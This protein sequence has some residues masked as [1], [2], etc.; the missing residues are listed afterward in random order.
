MYDIVV[1]GA[2]PSGSFLSYSLAKSGM[3]VLT[4]E[5]HSE[6]GRPVECTGVVTKRVF[7]FVHSK[8][9]ANVVHGARVFFPGEDPIHISKGEETVI[10]QRDS[11]DKD[12]ASMA[13][14]AG[15]EMQLGARLTAVTRGSEG[16]AVSFK[17][18]GNVLQEKAK[19]IVGADGANSTVRRLL[20]G[21]M[22]KRVVSTYQAEIPTRMQSQDDVDVYLGSEVSRGFFGWAV[23]A[24]NIS[25]VGVGT[26]GPG[27]KDYFQ[28]ICRK[29]GFSG[30]LSITGGPIPVSYL[31]RTYGNGYLLIGDA[32]GIVKPL[33]GGG[34]YTGIV[35]ASEASRA[36]LEAYEMNNFSERILSRY[37]RYWKNALGRELSLDGL[38]QKIFSVIG[39]RG[40]DRIFKFLSREDMLEM[41][42][43]Y[44]DIDYPSRLIMK[45]LT[46]KP[47]LL[48]TLIPGF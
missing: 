43:S 16:W 30:S 48:F 32:A 28:R 15:A 31:K 35:S 2:G 29:F 21:E 19:V 14:D 46:R 47:S 25:R 45:L 12:V 8:S 4:I 1:V 18:D 34:I 7:N 44:G 22:P 37:Q 27:A 24:G 42:N 17:K 9:I 39:D 36:I 20:H 13:I 23:P 6:I 38:V 5:E 10:I 33:T 26:F 41:I 40:L 3:K 11:F